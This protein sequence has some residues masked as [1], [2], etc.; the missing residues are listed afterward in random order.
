MLGKMSAASAEQAT[1]DQPWRAPQH[2]GKQPRMHPRDTQ[3]VAPDIEMRDAIAGIS[4]TCRRAE[5]VDVGPEQSH[6]DLGIE[7]HAPAD[8][9][10]AP[11]LQG[12]GERIAEKADNRIAQST[13]PR[14]DPKPPT[15]DVAASNKRIRHPRT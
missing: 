5:H 13:G 6:H 10:R 7:V 12:D 9:L 3:I 14:V 2:A 4:D 11:D 1:P 15:G 8:V